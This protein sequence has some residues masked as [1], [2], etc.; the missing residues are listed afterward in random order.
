MKVVNAS[1][2]LNQS[3]QTRS[4]STG[5]SAPSGTTDTGSGPA[6]VV[7]TAPAQTDMVSGELQAGKVVE[8][9]TVTLFPAE[10]TPATESYA[11]LSKRLN[12]NPYVRYI[13]IERK[14]LN[15]G[16]SATLN[17]YNQLLDAQPGL[18]EQLAQT[19]AGQSLLAALDS[20]AKGQL[21]TED[22]IKLQT[23]IVSSGQDISHPHSASGIDGDYGPR[24]HAGLQQ[25]FAQL[26]ASPEQVIQS[27]DSNYA[28]AQQLAEAQRS[29]RRDMG[30]GFQPGITAY[31]EAPPASEAYAPPAATSPIGAEIVAQARRAKPEM[32]SIL[33]QLQAKSGRPHYRCYQGVKMVLNRI[34]PPIKLTGGSAY[35]A[36]DQLRKHY[37]DRFSD[38]QT[39][40]PRSSRTRAF[41]KNLPAGAIVV[42]GRN[43]NAA[44]RAA[45]PHNGYSHG[46]ISVALGGG[47]E[48]SDRDRAQITNHDGRYS[49]VT[50]FFP[51]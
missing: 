24:T 18:R 9:A 40:D 10:S 50:V 45:N 21:S 19:A 41:L 37:A 3:G 47:M 36:A 22:I 29:D 20:A 49:S 44:T 42:W 39:L 34:D 14:D 30:Y 33:N 6:P 5:T 2:L 15:A 12:A 43:E 17:H 4:A 35:Q 26:L 28:Q 13:E 23:F 32:R 27:F 16:L 8:P 38:I 48:F 25:A 1:L 7:S 31:Q 51:K 46:H 11:D